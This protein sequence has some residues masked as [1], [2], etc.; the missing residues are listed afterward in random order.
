MY[1]TFGPKKKKSALSE[2]ANT[3]Y[4]YIYIYFLDGTNT[5]YFDNLFMWQVGGIATK[6]NHDKSGRPTPIISRELSVTKINHDKSCSPTPI[7]QKLIMIKVVA[8]LL[9]FLVNYQI[10]RET[11]I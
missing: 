5:I 6:I 10:V 2:N 4:I 11:N 1:Q 3:I 8:L 7:I 9:S